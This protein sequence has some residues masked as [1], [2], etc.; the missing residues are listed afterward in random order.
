MDYSSESENSY[1]VV[2]RPD[3][4][5]VDEDYPDPIQWVDNKNAFQS[6]ILPTKLSCDVT[7]EECT[8]CLELFEK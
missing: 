1:F 4:S 5:D 2:G 7:P 3:Y 6:R 8:I